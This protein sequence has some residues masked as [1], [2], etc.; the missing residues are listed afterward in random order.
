[1]IIT[2]ARLQDSTDFLAHTLFLFVFQ[3]NDFFWHYDAGQH[4]N[5][6][7]NH[8][9]GKQRNDP[10]Q[11][12]IRNYPLTQQQRIY[13]SKHSQAIPDVEDCLGLF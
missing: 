8:V 12:Q 5:K 1:M 3:L 6:E 4:P 2:F 7:V 9:E 10:M 11:A 13:M